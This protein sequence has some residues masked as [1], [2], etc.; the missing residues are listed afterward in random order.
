M[1]ADEE[2]LPDPEAVEAAIRGDMTRV[3]PAALLGRLQIVPYYPLGKK[4]LFGIIQ[5]KLGKVQKRVAD[6]YK[7]VLS[8]AD[9]VKEEIIRRCDNAASGARLIDAVISN[10]L[11]PEISAEFLRNT[12]E[13]KAFKT[14]LIDVK[15]NEFTYSFE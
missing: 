10:T 7:A 2:K 9:A 11:L 15:D 12:R 8:A 13:G 6:N 14:V 5:A 1:C 4:A 3:F